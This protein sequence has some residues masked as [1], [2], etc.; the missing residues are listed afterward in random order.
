MRSVRRAFSEIAA[1]LAALL[2]LVAPGVC[3]GCGASARLL[4]P[5]CAGVLECPVFWS[6]PAP[7]P[8]GLPPVA[9]VAPYDGP[10]GAVLVA[11]KDGGR[12][13]LARALGD[14]LSRS[15]EACVTQPGGAGNSASTR[16]RPVLVMPVPSAPSAARRRG[17]DPMRRTAVRAVRRLR[18]R[19]H[20]VQLVPALRQTRRVADQAGLGATERASNLR[21]AIGVAPWAAAVVA[22]RHVVVV[23]D[24]VT[25]GATLA[26][27]VRAVSACGGAVLGVATVA[28]TRRRRLPPRGEAS[29]SG[30]GVS[31]DPRGD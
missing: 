6:S 9:S 17:H 20:A 8:A 7:C 3:A 23:D 14:A 12:L 13:G 5:A 21:G 29:E 1:V 16:G 24:V 18:G 4:C 26:D 15:V 19:G 31:R 2:E 28:A 22:G 30:G 25:T 27:A 11:H 10:A